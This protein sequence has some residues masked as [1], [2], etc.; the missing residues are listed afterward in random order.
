MPSDPRQQAL[1]NS[2]IARLEDSRREGAGLESKTR[3]V[4]LSGRGGS[5]RR[6]GV[7]GLLLRHPDVDGRGLGEEWI[8][9]S[10]FGEW[11]S[12][13]MLMENFR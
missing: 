5:V 12:E 10:E 9:F 13:L 7:V 8:L 11:E 1:E 4:R 6:A 2:A 3:R